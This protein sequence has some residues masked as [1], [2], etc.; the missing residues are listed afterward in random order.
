M[1]STSFFDYVLDAGPLA[2]LALV[3][4]VLLLV[5][6][7]VVLAQARSV[8]AIFVLAGLSFFPAILG[9]AGTMWGLKIINDT[10]HAS[11]G[12]ASPRE[13]DAST[14][15]AWS[16]TVVG[17]SATAALLLVA[18]GGTFLVLGRNADGE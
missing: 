6:S 11:P 7:F 12:D 16:S 5:V 8:G 17:G 10:L 4:T 15:Q 2:W 14:R 1:G 13:R 18:L 3:V 9:F